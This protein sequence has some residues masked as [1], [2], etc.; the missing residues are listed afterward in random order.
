MQ[1]SNGQGSSISQE[2]KKTAITPQA[3]ASDPTGRLKTFN[4]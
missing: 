4:N 2:E 1:A 3:G